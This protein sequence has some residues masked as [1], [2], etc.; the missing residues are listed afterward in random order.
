M[1]FLRIGVHLVWT[2]KDRL[3]LL[4]KN[5]RQHVFDHIRKYSASKSIHINLI[6]GHNEHVHALVSLQADQNIAT[7]MNLLK[8]ES[9][10]W[11]NQ[12]QLTSIHFG[13]QDEYFAA[14]VSH[15]QIDKVQNYIRKQEKHHAV[16]TWEEEYQE[17]FTKYK[18]AK[19]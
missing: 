19:G 10:H 7:I 1:P 11:I 17:F 5:I 16:R 6:N 14:S 9:S 13:W 4:T 8:G 15:S 3:P 2:T 12:K 18:F